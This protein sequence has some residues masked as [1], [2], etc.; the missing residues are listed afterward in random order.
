MLFYWKANPIEFAGG[1]LVIAFPA[2]RSF[3]RGELEKADHHKVL[4][5]ALE[6]VLGTAVRVRT[7]LEEEE[8]GLDRDAAGGERKERGR[9]PFAAD[10]RGPE[11]TEGKTDQAAAGEEETGEQ[12]RAPERCMKRRVSV[13]RLRRKRRRWRKIDRR[14][15][16][17]ARS[18]W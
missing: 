5:E 15:T 8:K 13:K 14:R 12:S 3:H 9:K 16:T 11:V 7:R 6:E 10:T 17:P 4:E 1:E 2:D 18:S